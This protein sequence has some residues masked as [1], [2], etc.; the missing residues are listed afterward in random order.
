[1]SGVIVSIVSRNSNILKSVRAANIGTTHTTNML[2]FIGDYSLTPS[3]GTGCFGIG[4]IGRCLLCRGL[5]SLRRTTVS[6]TD[7]DISYLLKTESISKLHYI[8]NEL[9]NLPK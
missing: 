5:R 7:I 9:I 6:F 8:P 2:V 4:T 3:M 1:M